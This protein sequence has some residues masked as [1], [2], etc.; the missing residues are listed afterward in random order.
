ML[1][2]Y[3]SNETLSAIMHALSHIHDDLNVEYERIDREIRR[4]KKRGT[5][6][7]SGGESGEPCEPTLENRILIE[8]HENLAP[9][10][11]MT[12]GRESHRD[13]EG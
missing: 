1:P 4:R 11:R 5:W 9:V 6:H 7:P 13:G 8:R 2:S 10:L 3:L 12:G